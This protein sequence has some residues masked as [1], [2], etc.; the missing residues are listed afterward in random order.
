MPNIPNNITK[1]SSKIL[2]SARSRPWR[3]LL[4]IRE[5]SLAFKSPLLL[6]YGFAVIILIGTILLALPISSQS[7]QF[8]SIV[9]SLFTATS[10][11]CVTGLVVVDTG[12]YWSVFGQSVIFVLIQ[13]GGFGFM[14]SAT[15]FLLTL[16]RRMGLREKLVISEAIGVSKL[17]GLFTLIKRIALYTLIIE[18]IGAVFFYFSFSGDYSVG[19]SIWKAAFHSISSFN[20]AGFD[21]F[22]NF[23]SLAGFQNNPAFLITTSILIIL[24]GISFLVVA[25]IV[26]A[27]GLRNLSLDSKLVLITTALLL[28]IGTAVI[29][30]TEL[31]DIGKLGISSMPN[32]LLNS[33]FQSVTARTAGFSTINMAQIEDYALFFTMLLMFIGGAAGS[34]AGG[35]KVNNFGILTASIWSAIRGKEHPG[36]FKREF[37]EQQIYRAL[38]VVILS[39]GLVGIVV[40]LLTITEDFKFINLLFESISAFGTVGLSTGITPSL[41]TAGKMI[42]AVTMF[43][44]RLGPLTIALALI[45]RQKPTEFHYPKESI[46]IG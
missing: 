39:L 20:N 12:T 28:V 7:G 42:V 26:R 31:K 13:I 19:E 1:F 25:D 6:F 44:G 9:N 37:I 29:F 40:F 4:S 22:G 23:S 27:R 3:I 30:L 14:I 46:R 24:G 11:V 34:T 16:G 5:P 43:A 36:A 10:A 41:T 17:G 21:L 32:Q 45:Q 8:T 33:F 15:L 2:Y 35:I 38:A 18:A